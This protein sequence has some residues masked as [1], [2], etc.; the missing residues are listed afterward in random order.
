MDRESEGWKSQITGQ[1]DRARGRVWR[2]WNM[3]CNVAPKHKA[4]WVR[5]DSPEP[6]PQQRRAQLRLLFRHLWRLG[7]SGCIWHH[8]LLKGTPAPCTVP[9]PPPTVRQ[10]LIRGLVLTSQKAAT[11]HSSPLHTIMSKEGR[12]GKGENRSLLV[13]L[14]LIRKESLSKKPWPLARQPPVSDTPAL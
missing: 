3:T 9:S 8:R 7:T 13:C 4:S 10:Q 14:S 5:Q 6:L 1:G 2:S 12:E 11:A